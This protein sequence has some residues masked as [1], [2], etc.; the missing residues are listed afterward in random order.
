MT[1]CRNKCYFL[2]KR[3]RPHGTSA[4]CG[5]FGAIR[6]TAMQLSTTTGGVRL[7]AG[8]PAAVGPAAALLPS[9]AD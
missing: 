7:A 3:Q 5:S 2:Q 9:T 6:H 1:F 8:V 4:M